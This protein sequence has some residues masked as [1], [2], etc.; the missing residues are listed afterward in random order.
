MRGLLLRTVVV[1]GLG[2]AALAAILFYASTVDGRP[3]S[4]TRISL[5]QHLAGDDVAALTTTS[6][7]VEFSEPVEVA[8][9]SDAFTIEPAVAGSF[10]IA[11]SVLT[12]SPHDRLPIDTTFALHVASGV[13]DLAGNAMSQPSAPFSFATVG[14]PAVV[15]SDPADGAS[16]VAQDATIRLTFSTLMDTASVEAALQLS[17]AVGLELRWSQEEVTIVPTTPLLDSTRYT[18]R[19]GAGARDQTGIELARPF[20]LSFQTVRSELKIAT[21]VPADGLEGAAVAGPIAVI[22]DRSLDPASVNGDTLTITPNLAGNTEAVELPGAAGLE[23]PGFRILRFQPS[24]PMQPNTTY[25]VT[26]GTGVRSEDG[27]RL[28]AP[29]SWTFTTGA[30]LAS[31]GNQVLFLS[32]RSGISNVWSM[33][34]DGSGQRQVSAELS[35]VVEYVVAPDGRNVVVADGAVLVE[36]ATDGSRRRELTEAGAREFDP[37]FAP[38]GAMI[39]FGRADAQSGAGLGLWTRPVAGGDAVHLD[40]TDE[41][42]PGASPSPSLDPLLRTPRYSPDG[43]ALAFVDTSGRVAVLELPNGQLSSAAFGALAAPAWLPDSTGLLLTGLPHRAAPMPA[44]APDRGLPR[45]SPAELGLDAGQLAAV[46]I[47]TLDRGGTSVALPAYPAGT[48]LASRD[49]VG[50]IAYVTADGLLWLTTPSSGTSVPVLRDGG[51]A[52][53]DVAVGPG[54][55]SFLVTRQPNAIW[56]VDAADGTGLPLAADGW[57][58]RWV[59]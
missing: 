54:G 6:I 30:P 31:L 49:A 3:P 44:I 7:E 41:L 8:S 16:G 32:D 23:Q 10:S 36:L 58:A 18:L 22:F 52:P 34:P 25:R 47:A 14:H 55:G 19:L 15:S 2:L 37:T 4:V 48:V 12:F 13:R 11:G 21:L 5:T 51:A 38:D 9:A 26:L 45:L 42:L 53:R 46:R 57:L 1:F 33:N 24:G 27:T 56:L 39:A 28:A 43:S 20:S 35:P 59:P 50:R 29:R 17:P 40:L